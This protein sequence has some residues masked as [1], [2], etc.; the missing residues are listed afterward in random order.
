MVT[1]GNVVGAGGGAGEIS[2]GEKQNK[3]KNKKE[4]PPTNLKLLT[5]AAL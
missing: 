3:R 2:E 5:W 4:E 1:R